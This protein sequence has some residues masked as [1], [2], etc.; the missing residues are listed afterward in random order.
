M[1]VSVVKHCEMPVQRLH[2]VVDTDA[3]SFQALWFKNTVHVRLRR[4]NS[5]IT[6]L[7]TFQCELHSLHNEYCLFFVF[8]SSLFVLLNHS[9]LIVVVH[10]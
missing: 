7:I 8:V 6:R 5:L 3:S 4:L 2:S 9:S 1:I 10:D